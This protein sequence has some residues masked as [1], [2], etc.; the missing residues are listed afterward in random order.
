MDMILEKCSS[1][2]KITDDVIVF[3]KTKEDHDQNLHNLMKTVLIEGFRF[4]SDKCT[5]EHKQ[6]HFCGAIYNEK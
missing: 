5:I 1:T 3:G 4:T 6:I 2:L